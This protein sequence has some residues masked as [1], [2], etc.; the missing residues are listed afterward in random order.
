MKKQLLLLT[1]TAILCACTHNPPKPYGS[2][3]P[4]NSAEYYQQ[5]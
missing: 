4:L 2:E 5:K 3:F 1:L